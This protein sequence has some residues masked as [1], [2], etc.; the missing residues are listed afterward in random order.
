[1]DNYCRRVAS[2]NP[3]VNS[4]QRIIAIDGG[5][6]IRRCAQLNAFIIRDGAFSFQAADDFPLFTVTEAQAE[7]GGTINITWDDRPVELVESGA[8]FSVVRHITT[9]RTAAIPTA[10]LF[11]DWEGRLCGCSGGTDYFL[12]VN[13]GETVSLV[14]EFSDRV[15]A[16]KG[17]VVGWVMKERIE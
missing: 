17:G 16:K 7:S 1:V 11:T 3:I 15:L 2:L 4:A 5:M 8:E 10:Y 6:G 14:E 12:P 13:A 9:G